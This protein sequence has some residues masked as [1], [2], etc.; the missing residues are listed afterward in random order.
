[1]MIIVY[2]NSQVTRMVSAVSALNSVFTLTGNSRHS[3]PRSQPCTANLWPGFGE[4]CCFFSLWM[5]TN[6]RE[7][8]RHHNQSD[9]RKYRI[10]SKLS[11]LWIITSPKWSMMRGKGNTEHI[12]GII[13]F[14]IMSCLLLIIPQHD[15]VNKT[16]NYHQNAE[17]WL[18][19]KIRTT[20]CW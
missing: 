18:Q 4:I 9:R 17:L 20:S 13:S 14:L 6:Q 16:T 1:M 11:H 3:Q 10:L 12:T 15:V 2:H 7:G 19:L 5:P 8:I